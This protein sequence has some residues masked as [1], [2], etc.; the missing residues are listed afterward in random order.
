[1]DTIIGLAI[2]IGIG[3]L[4]A[5]LGTQAILIFVAVFFV[6]FVIGALGGEGL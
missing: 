5:C 2:I 1:M 3:A 4:C 6:I